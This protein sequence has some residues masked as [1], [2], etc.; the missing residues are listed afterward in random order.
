M[1]LWATTLLA[2]AQPLPAIICVEKDENG[3]CVFDYSRKPANRV[4][5]LDRER[6]TELYYSYFLCYY[7]RLTSDERFGTRDGKAA[8]AAMNSASSDC[9]EM[10]VAA[11]AEVDQYLA[12]TK[13]YGD[14][15]NRK[16]VSELFRH[17]MGGF[18]VY[19]TARMNNRGGEFETMAD[20]I[21]EELLAPND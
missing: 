18:F 13:I 10:R 1:G 7:E 5:A 12:D 17:E 9:A 15:E 19:T 11:E 16:K 20:A 4:H 21:T 2:L 6:V 14:S 8:I 3:D